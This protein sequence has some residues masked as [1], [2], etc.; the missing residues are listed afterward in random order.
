MFSGLLAG[1]SGFPCIVVQKRWYDRQPFK[2]RERGRKVLIRKPIW[3]PTAPTKLYNIRQP[4]FYASD[5]WNQLVVSERRFNDAVRSLQKYLY[6][7]VYSASITSGG[8]SSE[9]VKAE[10]EEQMR[11]LEENAQENERVRL[12]REN[13]TKEFNQEIDEK[14]MLKE[15]TRITEH[16]EFKKIAEEKVKQEIESSKTYITRD[17]LEEAIEHA[18]R[19]PVS[20]NFAIDLNG[21]IIGA[22]HPNALTPMHIPESSGLEPKEPR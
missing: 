19:N 13:M 17:R 3:F 15:Y 16:E 11:L 20:Y 5:E 14:A 7:E 1:N 21:K 6:D 10:S 2:R 22:T 8:F 4:L 18:L 12:E 9:E